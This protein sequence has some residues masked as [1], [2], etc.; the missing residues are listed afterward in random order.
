MSTDSNSSLCQLFG[1]NYK[2]RAYFMQVNHSLSLFFE[3][4][5]EGS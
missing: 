4:D 1:V 5:I 3:C 2:M